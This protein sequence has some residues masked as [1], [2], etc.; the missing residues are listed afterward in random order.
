MFGDNLNSGHEALNA[1]I[2]VRMLWKK[3]LS[4]QLHLCSGPREVGEEPAL[5]LD[6]ETLRKL[7]GLVLQD[8][9]PLLQLLN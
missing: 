5:L 1:D 2:V 8:L 7:L 3:E 6:Q 4:R 9:D